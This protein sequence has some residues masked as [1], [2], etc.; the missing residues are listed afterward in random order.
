MERRRVNSGGGKALL[1]AIVASIRKRPFA[2]W[3]E[4][5]D[6]ECLGACSRRGR[7]SISCPGKWAIAFGGLDD[8]TDTGPLCDFIEAWLRGAYGEVKLQDRPIQIRKK[9]IGRIPP[10]QHYRDCAAGNPRP[11]N[12]VI[13]KVS[14]NRSIPKGEVK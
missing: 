8:R 4:I 7:V 11:P 9:I 12:Q 6:F 10:Q 5:S 1:A 3:V 14:L 13:S 2:E